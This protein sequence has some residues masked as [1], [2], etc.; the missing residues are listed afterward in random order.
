[1]I[2]HTQ[3]E[4]V[5]YFSYLGSMTTQDARSTREIKSRSAIAKAAFNTRLYSP[6][7]WT[8]FN[9]ETSRVCCMWRAAWYGAETCDTWESQSE[10]PGKSRNVVLQKDGKDKLD[11]SC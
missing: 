4:N 8:L 6:V 5:E 1:M 11:R 9:K 2:D 10:I 7:N 3:C